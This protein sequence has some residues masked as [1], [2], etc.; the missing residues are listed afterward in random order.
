M[1]AQ[2]DEAVTDCHGLKL[3]CSQLVD[4]ANPLR[5]EIIRQT[6][7]DKQSPGSHRQEGTL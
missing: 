4:V 5:V 2:R 1:I 7:R 3:F 6:S